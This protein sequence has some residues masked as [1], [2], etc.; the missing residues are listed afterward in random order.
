MA[1]I[2]ANS[3]KNRSK[4]K[5]VKKQS[6]WPYIIGAGIIA[7][8]ALPIIV[9]AI[10]FARLPG[11]FYRSQGNAHVALGTQTPAYRS[12][13]PTSG[14]HTGEL[15]PWGSHDSLQHDQQLVHNMEDGGVILWYRYGSPED[16][17]AHI[18]ALEE[19]ARG[20]RRIVIAPRENMST[21]YTLTAWTRLQRF[22]EIDTEGMRAFIQAYEGL[23]HHPRF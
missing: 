19:V 6:P 4:T 1:K 17:E 18:Q 5:V 20:F 16:N 15:A 12:D 8:I 14:W 7:L 23:D 22:D 11:E 2:S 13:P 21:T 3:A 9:N 10:N